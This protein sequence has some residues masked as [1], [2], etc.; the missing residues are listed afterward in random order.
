MTKRKKKTHG[1]WNTILTLKPD[2]AFGFIYLVTNT[3]SGRKYV[4]KKQYYF[5]RKGKKVSK[6]KWET[7]T[8]SSK[9]LNKDIKDL[10][11]DKFI[12]EI[13]A[14]YMTRG[15]LT[16]AEANLQHKRDVLTTYMTD[17]MTPLYYNK[18]IGAIRYMPKRID[19]PTPVKRVKK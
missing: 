3:V 16:Y 7:Y 5:Y 6:S 8:G 12:F 10:G 2:T 11:K 4:G 19:D 9:E 17:D 14:E 1:H 13:L 15:W 18:Q